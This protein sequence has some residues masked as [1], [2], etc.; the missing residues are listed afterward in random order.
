MDHSRYTVWVF[1][2]IFV[3]TVPIRGPAH[4]V[5]T[6]LI[7]EAHDL[8]C[9][10]G[11]FGPILPAEIMRQRVGCIVRLQIPHKILNTRVQGSRSLG[12]LESE[13]NGEVFSG[14]I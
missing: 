7:R 14:R 2:C 1:K 12:I 8:V 3:A 13:N 5:P 11:V 10:V 9:K 6:L 4:F